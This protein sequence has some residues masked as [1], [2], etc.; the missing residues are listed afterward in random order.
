MLSW[1]PVQRWCRLLLLRSHI[2][3]VRLL[4][5]ECP[6]LAGSI[7]CVFSF[8]V[9]SVFVL[10]H[11]AFVL[12]HLFTPNHSIK[13]VSID[14]RPII[15]IEQSISDRRFL[16]ASHCLMSPAFTF[17]WFV[18]PISILSPLPSILQ[19]FLCSSFIPHSFSLDSQSKQNGCTSRRCSLC[20]SCLIG[21]SLSLV[22]IDF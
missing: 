8:P 13:Q 6:R 4:L 7:V 3:V 19:H 12:T 9:R 21:S 5:E 20:C 18:V 1:R 11:V 10:L 14:T 22:L 2:F 17:C 16:L 15:L